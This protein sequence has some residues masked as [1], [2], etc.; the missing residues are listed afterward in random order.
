[1]KK[2][3]EIVKIRDKF[4]PF[5]LK[6]IKKGIENEH[7]IFN[8]VIKEKRSKDFNIKILFLKKSDKILLLFFLKNIAIPVYFSFKSL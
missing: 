5:I 1:M 6:F 2:N 7:K 8:K 3:N 4:F